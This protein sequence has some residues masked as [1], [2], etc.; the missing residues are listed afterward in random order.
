MWEREDSFSLTFLIC[1]KK[2]LFSVIPVFPSVLFL[3]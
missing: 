2:K 1:L 3:I